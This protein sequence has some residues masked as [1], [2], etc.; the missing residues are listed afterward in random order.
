MAAI[1]IMAVATVAGIFTYRHY[2]KS[3]QAQT[4]SK[5]ETAQSNYSGGAKRPTDV[6]SGGNQ[7]GAKD[8]NGKAPDTDNQPVPTTTSSGGAITVNGLAS[9]SSL[10]SGDS[11]Y[12][13]TT[14]S[15]PV[16]FRVIDET[17]GVVAQGQLN[18]VNGSFSGKLSFTA[19]STTGRLDVYTTDSM[20]S[21]INNIEI[22]VQFK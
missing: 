22:P 15:G 18:V 20:G 17:D 10:K 6:A 11:L 13:T 4:T 5:S 3:K 8:N 1:L 19:R 7:G 14:V 21:E 16:S 2:H 12:G 9:N